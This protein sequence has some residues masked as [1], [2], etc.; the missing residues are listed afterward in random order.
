M[1]GITTTECCCSG[2]AGRG[3]LVPAMSGQ[4]SSDTGLED[5]A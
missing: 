4:V 2:Y 3:Q 5:I 1:P